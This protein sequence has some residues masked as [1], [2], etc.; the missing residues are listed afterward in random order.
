MC[1]VCWRAELKKLQSGSWVNSAYTNDMWE[2]GQ[3]MMVGLEFD[4][5]NN[6]VNMLES[7]EA[8]DRDYIVNQ[9]SKFNTVWTLYSW[10]D[11]I[12]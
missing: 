5:N 11:S 12:W 7:D 1:P 3:E 10:I 4:H 8:L 9:A 6:D 2:V